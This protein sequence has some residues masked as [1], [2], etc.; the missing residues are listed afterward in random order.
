[1]FVPAN[2]SELEQL[3]SDDRKCIMAY[4]AISYYTSHCP[5]RG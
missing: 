4:A 1:M 5:V 3:L 2:L